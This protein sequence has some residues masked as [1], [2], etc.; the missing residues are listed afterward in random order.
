MSTRNSGREADVVSDKSSS[1]R[2]TTDYVDCFPTPLLEDIV[3]SR[4][5]PF[6]GS[7]FSLNGVTADGARMP[8]WDDLGRSVIER[9]PGYDYTTA[10]EAISAYAHEFS[11]VNLIEHI[12][13]ALLID[14]IRPGPAHKQF[15]KLDFLQVVTTNWDFLL[16]RGYAKVG[17]YVL[18]LISEEQLSLATSHGTVKLLKFH[19]DLHHPQRM[20]AT[21]DD[22]DTFL[23]TYPLFATY[24]SSLLIDRTALFIG[25][26]LDDP[27]FRQIW[28]VLKDRLGRLRRQAYVL[29]IDQTP[30]KVARYERRGVKVVNIPNPDGRPCGEV[31]ADVFARL[32][33]FWTSEVAKSISSTDPDPQA[34]FKL[35]SNAQS[36][37]AFFDVPHNL[38]AQYKEY[39]YPVAEDSGFSPVM[40]DDVVAPGDNVL[41][42]V[43]A[44]VDKAAVV[45]VEFGPSPRRTLALQSQSK[46]KLNTKPII[47]IE[48]EDDFRSPFLELISSPKTLTDP[49]LSL[50]AP[51]WSDAESVETFCDRLKEVFD[52]IFEDISPA[53]QNEPRRLLGKEEYRAAVIAA[54]SLLEHELRRVNESLA[55]AGSRSLRALLLGAERRGIIAPDELLSASDYF[56]IRNSLTHSRDEIDSGLAVEI[57]QFME[58]IT[59]KVKAAAADTG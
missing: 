43:S 37:L 32:H 12:S 9:L 20:T 22:Y 49:R 38:A 8:L 44:L 17:K 46:D 4:C 58:S 55:L 59:S 16:E 15:C 11:R 56:A 5:L 23:A 3:Q 36:R 31:F 29:Q 40:A 54:V 24:L 6:V 2:T 21:E 25:Y 13:A 1:E 41:V 52:Q 30:S 47:T 35:P 26:S 14:S 34:E 18:P 51:N 45:V 7:G 48:N 19:G 57:V 42:K 53:L 39:V 27:D 50:V 28:S 33:D 10:L